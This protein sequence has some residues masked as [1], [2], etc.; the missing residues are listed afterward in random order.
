N[1]ETGCTETKSFRINEVPAYPAISASTFP[2]TRCDVSQGNGS[3]HVYVPG[4]MVY[5]I[6][7]FSGELTTEPDRD[8]PDAGY[9]GSTRE[10]KNL[11]IGSY[12]VFVTENGC[13]TSAIVRVKDGRIAP[14]VI[15]I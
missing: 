3:A 2:V 7:W 12:T 1:T 4:A 13:T 14:E 8:D 11:D 6:N 15:M 9:L 5:T 10:I